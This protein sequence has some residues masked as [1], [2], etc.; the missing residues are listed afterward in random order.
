MGGK[1]T[2]YHGSQKLI[3]QP[4]YGA[5]NVRNDYGLGFYCTE[6]MEMYPYVTGCFTFRDLIPDRV[7]WLHRLLY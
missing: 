4:V 3:Q 5:G 1:L 7:S 6:N 2:I